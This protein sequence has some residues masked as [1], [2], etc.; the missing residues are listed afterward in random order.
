V[1]NPLLKF[2]EII[3]HSY[4]CR[5]ERICLSPSRTLCS[6]HQIASVTELHTVAEEFPAISSDN[7]TYWLRGA[8][9]LCDSFLLLSA[10]FAEH[11]DSFGAWVMVKHANNVGKRCARK[12]LATNVDLRT[13]AAPAPPNQPR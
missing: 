4:A 5:T 2:A 11:G 1:R 12:A 7:R 6:R 3:E 8:R 10:E 9:D 13:D